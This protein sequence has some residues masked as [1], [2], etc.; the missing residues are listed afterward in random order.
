MKY[1]EVEVTMFRRF[2]VEVP[3]GIE[4]PD[5]WADSEVYNFALTNQEQRSVTGIET[6]ITEDQ[7][8]I[9]GMLTQAEFIN[10]VK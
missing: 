1:V 6:Y 7:E 4:H 3:E 9:A 2:M 5:M 8:Y 10:L